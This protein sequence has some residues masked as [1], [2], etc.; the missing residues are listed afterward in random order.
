MQTT[1]RV[2]EQLYTEATFSHL[3]HLLLGIK[4]TSGVGRDFFPARKC[5]SGIEGMNGEGLL[6]VSLNH[7]FGGKDDLC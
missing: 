4:I 7:V 3:H 1:H 6:I 5:C 2:S